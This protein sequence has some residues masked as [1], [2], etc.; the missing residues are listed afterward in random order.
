MLIAKNMDYCD[1]E[2]YILMLDLNKI[3]E[4]LEFSKLLDDSDEVIKVY[5]EKVNNDER[6]IKIIRWYYE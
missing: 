1:D 2:N 4:S 5:V 3:R 6:L